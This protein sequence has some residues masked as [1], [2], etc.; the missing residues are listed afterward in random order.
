VARLIEAL[1]DPVAT[2]GAARILRNLCTYA[3]E[4][5]QLVLRGVTA[6][7][8]KVRSFFPMI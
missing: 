3:G 5:W 4:E 8:T 6:G 2:I 1:G 7:A